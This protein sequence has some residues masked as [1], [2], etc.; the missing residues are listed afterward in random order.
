M[1]FIFQSIN[2]TMSI[3]LVPTGNNR[4][5]LNLRLL[6]DNLRSK[7]YETIF[8]SVYNETPFL[9]ILNRVENKMKI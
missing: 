4:F 9:R 6:D 8:N 5:Y 7:I 3:G 2:S 1:Q